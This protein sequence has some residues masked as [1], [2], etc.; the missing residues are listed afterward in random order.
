MTSKVLFVDDEPNVLS[1]IRR[2]LRKQEFEVVTAESPREGLEKVR[3]DG[4]FAAVVSDMRMPDMDGAEFLSLV[5]EINPDT[6]R[7]I[8]SGQAELETTIAAVNNGQIFRFLTKPCAEDE[9]TA[10]LDAAL[11][12]Y[13]LINVE[14]DLL[15]KTLNGAITML[16][17]LLGVMNPEAYRRASRIRGYAE[18]IG[19]SVGIADD[20][21]FKL[22]TLL[23]QIGCIMLPREIL[24]KIIFGGDLSDEERG[25]Y[26][27]H[28]QV[29][30]MLL[31]G[32][33]RLEGVAVILSHQL[34]RWDMASL[35]PEL[36]R[37]DKNILSAEILR[38]STDLDTLVEGGEDHAAA[39]KAL[40]QQLVNA[41]E[42]LHAAV[43]AVEVVKEHAEI[44]Q[45]KISQLEVGM[46][47]D[48]DVMCLNGTL[49][50]ASGQEI[51]QSILIRM[52]NIAK[53]VGIK[54]P[55][56]IRMVRR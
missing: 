1:A 23:S 53:S 13:E 21:E 11:K 54:E 40:E 50:L 55:F 16:T 26:E 51:S 42:A 33:P 34:D 29:A 32:I 46:V 45:I 38:I 39:L 35:P 36:E 18:D 14:R 49:L 25:L 31:A 4:P 12:Q 56:R 2:T 19:T 15:E 44:R 20:W 27:S 10:V 9:L 30:G 3:G 37:W 7:I 5:R 47:A 48:E 6:V 24:P 41:P 22:A 17:E 28:P 43:S 52:T 8:L